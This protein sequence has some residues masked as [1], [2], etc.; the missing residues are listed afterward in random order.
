MK[1]IEEKTRKISLFAILSAQRDN[2]A[3]LR[4]DYFGLFDIILLHHINTL[5]GNIKQ[6]VNL[7]DSS[8]LVLKQ[9]KKTLFCTIGN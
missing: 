3:L 8:N 9:Q 4:I 7:N 1:F 2:C 6:I 5:N